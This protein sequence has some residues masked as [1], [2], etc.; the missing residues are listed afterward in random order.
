[1]SSAWSVGVATVD[2]TPETPQFLVGMGWRTERSK[3]VYLPLKASALYLNDGV[4]AAVLLSA[5]LIAIPR[6]LLQRLRRAA[7]RDAGV[8]GDHVIACATHTHDAPR[9]SDTWS[10]RARSTRPT[11]AGWRRV[12]AG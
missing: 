8:P 4:T 12:C 5:D 7:S 6:P 10:W 2:I 9:I 11:C 1:M 3:G